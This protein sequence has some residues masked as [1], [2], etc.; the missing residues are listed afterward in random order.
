MFSAPNPFPSTSP[1]QRPVI[2]D[3]RCS[4]WEHKLIRS[5]QLNRTSGLLAHHPYYHPFAALD[6]GVTTPPF[7]LGADHQFLWKSD[8]TESVLATVYFSISPAFYFP[9]PR[10]HLTTNVHVRVEGLLTF[11]WTLED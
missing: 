4:I 10:I 1:V 2:P 6:T 8:F 9:T 5:L 3:A 11:C 7:L